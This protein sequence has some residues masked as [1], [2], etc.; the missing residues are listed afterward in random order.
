MN[1]IYHYCS[2]ETFL[3]IIKNKKLWLGD[4]RYMNDFMEVN[5][6]MDSFRELLDIELT[7][8][9][10]KRLFENIKSNQSMTKP[11]ICCLSQSGDI[12]SQW[13]AYAQD[14]HGIAIGFDPNKLDVTSNSSVHPNIYVKNSFFLN[15][16]KYL[17]K[18]EIRDTVLD[19][20]KK[21]PKAL[22]FFSTKHSNFSNLSL[23]L[24]NEITGLSMA[25]MHMALHTKN[26]AFIEEKEVRLIY[27]HFPKFHKESSPENSTSKD[28]LNS[29]KM[30]ISNGNLTS[31]F[32]FMIPNEAISDI[33]L[34]PKC[35]FDFT[36]VKDFILL[37]GLTHDII[38][39]KSKASYR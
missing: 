18:L 13:R 12:L 33:I 39:D 34:G 16:I 7:E 15:N 24:Q 32:E 37:N 11:Y 27:N 1:K 17:T 6:F 30:R 26:P 22:D 25:I 3:N 38:I 23:D 4:I 5:W 29:K 36:D 35:N 28:F 14:G 19:L 8:P 21:Y 9:Q 20:L 10:H 2:T 31:Y